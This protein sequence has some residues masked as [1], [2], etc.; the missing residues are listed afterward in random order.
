MKSRE[1]FEKICKRQ[2]VDRF[3]IDYLAHPLIDK[4]IKDFY[5]IQSETELLNIIEADFYYLSCRDISQNESCL[6][7]YI[8]PELEISQKQRMCPFGIRWSRSA[9]NSKFAVDDAIKGPLENANT[10]S[11]ILRHAWPKADWFDFDPLVEEA[12][13]NVNRI[14]IG[15]LWS[16]MLGDSY[17]MIGFENFLLHIA[18][19]PTMIKTLIR[20]MTDFYLEMNDL[21]FQKLKGKLDI[22]FFGNDFGSQTGLLFHENMFCEFFLPSI[23]QLAALA[24]GYN[25]KVMMHSCGAISQIIPYLIDAGID[26]IDPVQVLA[27]DMEPKTTSEK[28]KDLI[29][30]HGGIDTQDLLINGTKEQIVNQCKETISVLG[31]NNNYI[32]A[33]S[34]ILQ[35]DIPVENIDTMYNIAKTYLED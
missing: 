14:T 27:K 3:P 29:I 34:Q 20:K 24:H 26:I 15:G 1:R 25:L 11:D 4:K 28:F 22:F 8:G 12:E 2:R 33:P 35:P 16:G 31:A 23:K 18:L 32:F 17:R 5:G 6:P 7:Y 21:L 19:S 10:A 9:F 13:Q 30:F